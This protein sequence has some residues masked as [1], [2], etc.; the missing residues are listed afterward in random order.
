MILNSSQLKLDIKAQDRLRRWFAERNNP[1]NIQITCVGLG[2]S[3]IDYQM[4]ARAN[5]IQN[6]AAPYN[7]SKIKYHLIYDGVVTNITGKITM[8]LR[9]ITDTGSVESLYNYPSS[10]TFSLGIVPPSLSNGYDFSIISFNNS[11]TGREG[12]VGFLQTLPDNYVDPN[13][14]QQ[15]LNEQYAYDIVNLPSGW[16][17]IIDHPNNSFLLAKPSNYIFQNTSGLIKIRGI[18]SSLT[19]T[20][21]FNI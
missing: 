13:N 11:S 2:D 21:V 14:V 9:R 20:V 18:D 7:V 5:S 6:L 12:F 3:D 8:F 1:H 19:K 15:R 4:A 16:E 17:F 10:M